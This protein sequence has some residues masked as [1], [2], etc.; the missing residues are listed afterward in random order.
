MTKYPDFDKDTTRAD[1]PGEH[2]LYMSSKWNEEFVAKH[3][4]DNKACKGLVLSTL[5]L[6]AWHVSPVKNEAGEVT[7]THVYY[8]YSADANGNIPQMIQNKTGPKIAI[9]AMQSAVKFLLKRKA[10]MQ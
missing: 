9:D 8:L 10:A 5:F 4:T 1:K 3:F 2:C 7:G 6:S